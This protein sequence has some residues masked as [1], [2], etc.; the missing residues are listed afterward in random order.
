MN[1]RDGRV[2]RGLQRRK[3]WKMT[4]D[5]IVASGALQREETE[6]TL[7]TLAEILAFARRRARGV[8]GAPPG[9]VRS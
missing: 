1:K 5:A 6:L 3:A 4:A 7:A 8:M 9:G 2:E